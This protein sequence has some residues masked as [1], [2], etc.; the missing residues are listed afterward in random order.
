MP[1]AGLRPGLA[2][3]HSNSEARGT[4]IGMS[5]LTVG[6]GALRPMHARKT[7]PR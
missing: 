1:R 4:F 5:R 3:G 6:G 7:S 2:I